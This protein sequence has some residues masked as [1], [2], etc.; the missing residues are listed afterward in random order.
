MKRN[1]LLAGAIAS[2]ELTRHLQ[3]TSTFIELSVVALIAGLIALM[4]IHKGREI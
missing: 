3:G 2:F 1:E 4:T